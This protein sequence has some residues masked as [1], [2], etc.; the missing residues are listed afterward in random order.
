MT[1]T[2]KLMALERVAAKLDVTLRLERYRNEQ[3]ARVWRILL[4]DDRHDPVIAHAVHLSD[5]ESALNL[6]LDE[7]LR[8]G[9]RTI[10]EHMDGPLPERAWVRAQFAAAL[11]ETPQ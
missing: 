4:R 3:G 7:A 6:A 2:D 10:F 5:G 8:D 9:E 11:N 1:D